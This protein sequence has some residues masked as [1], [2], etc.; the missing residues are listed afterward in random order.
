M[1]VNNFKKINITP[2]TSLDE[3]RYLLEIFFIAIR[4]QI[5]VSLFVNRETIDI[6]NIIKKILLS[7][8]GKN[9]DLSNI[10]PS[11]R[12][13]IYSEIVYNVQKNM[14]FFISD[15]LTFIKYCENGFGPI[16]LNLL[17][18]NLSF[19]LRLK[20]FFLKKIKIFL[21]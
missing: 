12:T 7:Y 4:D 10:N 14:P 18:N 5:F 15:C 21:K 13:R 19:I 17:D 16:P 6:K 11:L 1:I 9:I 3:T 2:S 8:K 20:N